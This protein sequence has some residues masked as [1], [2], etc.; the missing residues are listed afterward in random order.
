MNGPSLALIR[1]CFPGEAYALPDES[2]LVERHGEVV[3]HVGLFWRTVETEHGPLD[4][5]GIG[6]V[7]T[8]PTWRGCGLASGLLNVAYRRSR[9]HQRP[10]AM[11]FAGEVETAFYAARGFRSVPGVE[12]LLVAGGA[13]PRVLST[14]GYW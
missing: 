2:I 12:H 14:G 1:S 8:H 7:C 11:L 9:L 5:G 6:L 3:S 13:I 4:V 10:H